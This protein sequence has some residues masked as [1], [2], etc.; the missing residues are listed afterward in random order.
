MSTFERIVQIKPAFDKRSDDPKK[1]YGIHGCDLRMILKGEKGTVQF[2]L[3]T[4]WM[5]PHV[6]KELDARIDRQF[7]HLSCHPLPADLGYHALAPQYEDQKPM[8]LCEYLDGRECYYDGSGCNAENIYHELLR[9]GS[10]GVWAALEKYY[11]HTF[12]GA[13][14]SLPE[15]FK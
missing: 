3:Y 11:A 10:D 6:E 14:W 12:E 1:N 4:N 9:A 13:E 2:V 7:P 5:L 8:G 15:L